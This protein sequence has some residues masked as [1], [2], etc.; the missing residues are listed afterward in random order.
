MIK[1]KK[2]RKPIC[3]NGARE[4]LLSKVQPCFKCRTELPAEIL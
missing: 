2:A 1:K 3:Y 4:P